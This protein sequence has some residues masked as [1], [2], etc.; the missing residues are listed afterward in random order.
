MVLP[1]YTLVK[2]GYLTCFSGHRIIRTQEVHDQQG[3]ERDS[4]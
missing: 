3:T 2:R 1:P 4:S